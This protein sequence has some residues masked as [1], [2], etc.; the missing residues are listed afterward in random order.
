MHFFS[1][2]NAVSQS[3]KN[4]YSMSGCLAGVFFWEGEHRGRVMMRWFSMLGEF[5]YV[6]Q[7]CNCCNVTAVQF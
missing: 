7:V 1:H 5:M 4:G 2:P 6:P 3:L